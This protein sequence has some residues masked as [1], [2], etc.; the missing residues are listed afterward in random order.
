VT[1]GYTVD[2]D[3][4]W[5][6]SFGNRLL[7]LVRGDVRIELNK[8]RGEWLIGVGSTLTPKAGLYEPTLWQ[9]VLGEGATTEAR[10]TFADEAT[11]LKAVL[12]AV[13]VALT[14]A[15][16]NWQALLLARAERLARFFAKP[17]PDQALSGPALLRPGT[18]HPDIQRAAMARVARGQREKRRH[19]QG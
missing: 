12:P 14:T 6:E 17:P 16:N 19:R 5:P 10:P 7:T 13:E 1:R 3:Q 8:D 11:A 2:A 15:W 4:Y 9:L 18:G